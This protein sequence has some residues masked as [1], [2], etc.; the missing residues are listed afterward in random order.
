[1]FDIFFQIR[2]PHPRSLLLPTSFTDKKTG[3]APGGM[4]FFLREI[5]TRRP[6]RGLF[7]LFYFFKM[8]NLLYI[9][10]NYLN[11]NF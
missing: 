3:G 10:E 7:N 2:P 5:L 11:R 6:L 9:H 1:M 8:F 4:I